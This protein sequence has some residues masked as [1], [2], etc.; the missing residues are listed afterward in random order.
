MRVPLG[1]L[2]MKPQPTSL[3]GALLTQLCIAA[4]LLRDRMELVKLRIRMKL[5]SNRLVLV[6][7]FF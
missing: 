5:L 4:G 6:P 1:S 3:N 2:R 7:L